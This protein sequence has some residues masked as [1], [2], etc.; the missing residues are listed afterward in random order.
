MRD[1]R[2]AI[3]NQPPAEHE[4]DWAPMHMPGSVQAYGVLLVADPQTRRALFVSDNALDMLGISPVNV[5]NKSYLTLIDDE[6]NAL[7]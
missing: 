1:L 4:Y 6:G 3:H 5:L 2:A 7:S